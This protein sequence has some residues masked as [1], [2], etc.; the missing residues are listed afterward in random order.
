MKYILPN[1]NFHAQFPNRKTA[2]NFQQLIIAPNPKQ[3]F[4]QFPNRKTAPNFQQ[5]IIAPF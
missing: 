3:F 2:L 4:T 5:L 1:H